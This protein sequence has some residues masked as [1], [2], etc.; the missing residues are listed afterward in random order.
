[1]HGFAAAQAAISRAAEAALRPDVRTRMN[2]RR[3]ASAA[4]AAPTT[5]PCSGEDN[6]VPAIPTVSVPSSSAAAVIYQY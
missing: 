4:F 2:M 6:A 1:M 3:N 5:Q